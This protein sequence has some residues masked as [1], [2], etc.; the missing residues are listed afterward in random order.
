M[1]KGRSDGLTYEGKLKGSVA[2]RSICVHSDK[3]KK[4]PHWHFRKPPSLG[5]SEFS[6]MPSVQNALA[7]KLTEANCAL[8]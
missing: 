7:L 1:A 4:V 2:S 5:M 3:T 8:A 6:R